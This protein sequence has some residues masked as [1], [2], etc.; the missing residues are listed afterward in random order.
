MSDLGL[1]IARRFQPRHVLIACG[2]VL[3]LFLVLDFGDAQGFSSLRFFD[4]NDSEVSDRISLSSMVIGALLLCASGIAFSTAAAARGTRAGFW[5]K[6]AAILFALFGVEEILGIHSWANQHG[7]SW[8][9]SYLPFL[10][11][12]VLAWAEMA[13][14]M[15]SRQARLLSVLGIGA[16]L[17]S[18]MFDAARAG[19][20]HAYAVGE[21]LQMVAASLFLVSLMVHAH[22]P[23]L[24]RTV[25]PGRS[26]DLTVLAAFVDRL[27]PVKLAIGAAVC[28]FALG[29]MGSIS[30][31]VDYMRV[32]DVN[33]EQNYAS[34][35]SGLALWAAALMAAF[36]GFVRHES[37]RARRWWLALACV[38]LY[39][40]LDEMTAL[41]EELQHAT[42][43]WGQT[44]LMPVVVVGVAAWY[45]ILKE[46]RSNDLATLL[47]LAGAASW[48]VSQGIDLKLNEPAPWTMVPEELG[49]MAGSLLF[50][51][52]LL[53]ALRPLLADSLPAAERAAV[54]PAPPKSE[55]LPAQ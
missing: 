42:G 53:V 14:H 1:Q 21:M 32:F 9:V 26:G 12:A 39:L 6:A 16:F 29:V 33:K 13:R 51:F 23:R 28:V 8:N 27:D 31:S 25:E 24:A 22:D 35:F 7:V 46:I 36:N 37:L 47:L 34:V 19:D 10:V 41:H 43:I 18:A 45:M 48:V 15:E 17:G 49:E 3:A 4:L 38:F 30:H 20:G 55:L 44:F 2:A 5:F 50:A 40:G 54:R 52:S 11:V